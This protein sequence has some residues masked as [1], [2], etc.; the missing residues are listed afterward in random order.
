MMTA[1]KKQMMIKKI[2]SGQSVFLRYDST[3]WSV[4]GPADTLTDG[5]TVTVTKA[6][7]T[8]TRVLI[9]SASQVY[10]DETGTQYRIAFFTDAPV[11][12]HTTHSHTHTHYTPSRRRVTNHEDCL[13]LGCCGD[14][15]DYHGIICHRT[16]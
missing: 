12:R 15:C 13:S 16:H 10:T 5:A 7:G 6:N 8:T 4:A 9:T 14:S 3:R 2:A 1:D 11:E